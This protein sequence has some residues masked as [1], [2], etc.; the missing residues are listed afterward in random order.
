MN[1]SKYLV[2]QGD[3]LYKIANKFGVSVKDLMNANGLTGSL[4]YP[5]QVLLIPSGVVSNEIVVGYGESVKD[6]LDKYDL[7]EEDIYH[8]KLV[9]EQIISKRNRV[10]RI[11]DSI[12][13]DEIL[14]KNNLTSDELLRLNQNRWLKNGNDIIVG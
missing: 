10:Y 5:N 2:N 9:P 4:I 8:L 6:I 12:S 3:N 11:T 1:Y 13:I 14:R 7:D